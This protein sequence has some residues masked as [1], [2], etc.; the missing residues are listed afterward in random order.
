MRQAFYYIFAVAILCFVAVMVTMVMP[1]MRFEHATNFLGTKTDR[2]LAEPMFLPAFYVH[3]TTSFI[4]IALGIAQFSVYLFRNYPRLHKNAGKL[5]VG[6]IL[7]LAA[8]SGMVLA[9]FANGGLA[10]KVAFGLQCAVWWLTTWYAWREATRR[11]YTQ[12]LQMMLRSYAVTLAALALRTESYAMY[13]LFDTK[14]IET[15]TTVAWLS[16]VGNFLVA[17][18]LIYR[19]LPDRLIHEFWGR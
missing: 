9:W 16:W 1:Y 17:E 7:L 15:Y 10:V 19:R 13:Y 14:P 8:P 5:Y 18:W 4:S 12:H 11:N 3:I 6:S 2:V